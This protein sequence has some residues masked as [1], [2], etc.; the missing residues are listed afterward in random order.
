MSLQDRLEAQPAAIPS[1][2][3]PVARLAEHLPPADFDYIL[4]QIDLPVTDPNRRS[5]GIIVRVLADEGVVLRVQAVYNHRA[6][7][8]SCRKA[9]P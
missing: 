6:G 3:C 2:R 7:N 9:N 1:H 4:T 8:C 5:A